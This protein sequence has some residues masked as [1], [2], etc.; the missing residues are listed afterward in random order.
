MYLVINKCVRAVKVSNF[1]GHYLRKRSTL[2]I[3]VLGYIGIVWPK[4]HSPEVRSFPPGTPCIH[5]ITLWMMNYMNVQQTEDEEITEWNREM[6]HNSLELLK[7]H[8]GFKKHRFVLEVC[9]CIM[10]LTLAMCYIIPDRHCKAPDHVTDSSHVFMLYLTDIAKRPIMSRIT[11]KWK[12]SGKIFNSWC[13]SKPSTSGVR[14]ISN[15]VE[16]PLTK[17]FVFKLR[18]DNRNVECMKIQK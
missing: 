8:R 2:D 15:S 7:C 14:I 5:I 18:A 12:I 6:R 13:H 4:E 11:W 10:L 3:G 1:S 16:V 9:K 17:Y